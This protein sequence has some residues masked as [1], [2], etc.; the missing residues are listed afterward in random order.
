MVGS[1]CFEKKRIVYDY[2]RVRMVGYVCTEMRM[3]VYV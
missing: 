1:E 3:I 2:L